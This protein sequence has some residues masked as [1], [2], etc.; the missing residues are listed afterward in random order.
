[1]LTV[2]G[3]STP[4]VTALF[5]AIAASD[6]RTRPRTLTLHGRNQRALE[7]VGRRA[8]HLLSRFGWT[9]RT[10]TELDRALEGAR[11]VIHQ[12]RYGGWDGR[13]ASEDISE[14][15]GLPVDETLGPG[16]L[17]VAIRNAQALREMA[18]AIRT[19]CPDAWIVNLTN[20]L[21]VTTAL[22]STTGVARCIGLCELPQSTASRIA[23][24]VGVDSATLEWSYAGL[25]HRGFLYDLSVA[26]RPIIADLLRLLPGDDVLNVDRHDIDLLAAVPLKYFAMQRQRS[27]T[28]RR[29][30]VLHDLGEALLREIDQDCAVS[31]PSLQRRRMDWYATSVVPFLSTL[32]NHDKTTH[33]VNVM[34][35][36][37]IVVETKATVVGTVVPE[38][39]QPPPA[40]VREWLDRFTAHEK[41]VLTATQSPSTRAI[42]DALALDP[43][44]P[45]SQVTPLTLE[46]E[47][48]LAA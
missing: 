37:G 2:L 18:R 9:V 10:T 21:S 45:D 3:G 42:R 20:P 11:H 25:N 35:A 15:F 24:L 31:P 47:R 16:A 27:R 1:M 17:L 44:V 36:S 32:D 26:G 46:L 12:I 28:A 7:I 30:R 19:C 38:Q 14:R 34:G 6:Y 33:V 23:E 40:A 39:G 13:L 4:F 8:M 22:L 29:A 48:E 43:M 5:D 41:A